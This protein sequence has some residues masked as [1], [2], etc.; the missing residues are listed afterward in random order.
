MP[1]EKK[2][3]NKYPYTDFHELNLDWIVNKT[4]ECVD[5]V[6]AYDDRLTAAEGDIS[7]LK[8]RMTAAEGNITSLQGRMTTAETHIEIAEGAITSLQQ[9]V[10]E[11][12]DSITAL[13]NRMTVVE[14]QQEADGHAISEL[15]GDMQT[16]EQDIDDLQS[17]LQ[18]TNQDVDELETR[19]DS[20]E[21]QLIL[22]G[23]PLQWTSN[24]G[25]P[26]GSGN[27][28]KYGKIRILYLTG[29]LDD[30]SVA[31]PSGSGDTAV[32]LSETLPPDS[33]PSIDMQQLIPVLN[34]DDDKPAFLLLRIETTG[35]IKI[36]NYTGA[37]LPVGDDS[38]VFA[39][40]FPYMVS[41]NPQPL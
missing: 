17:G 36:N 34:P 11:A 39:F 12:G 6:T 7:G 4:E 40:A 38:P 35:A 15:I 2:F 41:T 14:N 10:S 37:T 18:N 8:T 23:S 1:T 22:A 20:V 31:V 33:R 13:G 28:Q 25:T 21:D 16:A 9:D 3:F 30:I 27:V 32:M 24:S 19:V 26:T 29:S 5:I